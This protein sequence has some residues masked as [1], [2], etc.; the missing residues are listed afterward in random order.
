MQSESNI[1][2]G[3]TVVRMIDLSTFRS[4]PAS[5]R[6]MPLWNWNGNVTTAFIHRELTRF[7]EEGFGGVFIHPRAGMETDYLSE[8]WFNLWSEALQTARALGLEC[9]VYDENSYPSAMAGGHVYANFPYACSQYAVPHLCSVLPRGSGLD[10]LATFNLSGERPVPM[11]HDDNAEGSFLVVELRKATVNPWTSW[12]PFVDTCQP[13]VAE[14]FI[15][16]T[17]EQYYQRFKQFFGKELKYFFADEPTAAKCEKYNQS[18]TTPLSRL[19]LREFEKERGYD[20][21]PFLCD[22][23]LA[24]P[25]SRRT[26]YDY[27]ATLQRVWVQNFIKPVSDWCEQHG[28]CFTG[29]L[30]EHEWPVPVSHPNSMDVHRHLQMPGVDMLAFQ[31]H[32]DGHAENNSYLLMIKEAASAADQMGRT[33]VLSETH[34]G[35]GHS[36]R[37]ED[38]KELCDWQMVHGINFINPHMCFETI[39]GA[40]KYDWPQTFSDHS[41]WFDYYRLYADYTARITNALTRGRRVNRTLLLHPTTSAW[42]DYSPMEIKRKR[43]SAEPDTADLPIYQSQSTLIQLFADQQVDFDLGDE[44]IMRD[45]ASSEKGRMAVGACRYDVIILPEAM[46]NWMESTLAVMKDYFKAGGLLLALRDAPSYVNGRK[47]NR[48]ANLQ[49]TFAEQWVTCATREL[50]L[51]AL[52]RKLPPRIATQEGAPLPLR[53]YHQ[54]RELDSGGSIHMLVHNAR[55]AISTTLRLRGGDMV[56]LDP[57]TGD[58]VALPFEAEEGWLSLNISLEP[59]STRLLLVDADAK[60]DRTYRAPGHLIKTVEPVLAAAE[61]DQPNSLMIDYCDIELPFG[62]KRY[63]IPVMEANE[64]LWKAQGFDRN[65]WDRAIQFRNNYSRF[66]FDDQSGFLLRYRFQCDA[67]PDTIS[68]ALERPHLYKCTLNG[69]P[70]NA[71]CGE[72]WLDEEIRSV[73]IADKV[74]T[75][76]NIIELTA[77][78]FDI[79]CEVERIYL[80]G[81]FDVEPAEK[82]FVVTASKHTIDLGSWTDQGLPCYRGSMHYYFNIEV[83]EEVLRWRVAVPSYLGALALV[84]VDGKEIGHAAFPPYAIYGDAPTPGPHELKITVVGDLHNLM[85]PHFSNGLPQY[86][87]WREAPASQPPGNNYRLTEQGLIKPPIVEYYS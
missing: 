13:Q 24:T 21:T 86:M 12:F 9:H 15:D 82:G 60:T 79:H 51:A 36:L 52:K 10:V 70:V 40:R 5:C 45:L 68:L 41:P 71:E 7:K 43:W 76:E 50:L 4:P 62:R 27:Y 17:H 23:F 69:K 74:T 33:R 32:F 3:N 65:I 31:Y 56:E 39:A 30:M 38:M 59:L 61:P 35:G 20:L 48:P 42:L 85:G 73:S 29:H 8:A 19:L 87:A 53:V 72:V 84:A 44:M 6:P 28:V 2:K 55:R 63:D 67:V 75:G 14:T 83:P 37:F 25:T 78:V 46:N 49:N 34:G 18:F 77:P 54:Y 66:T 58:T 26:R 64:R 81:Y 22:L 80:I 11:A 16:V 47:D 1:G 57:V